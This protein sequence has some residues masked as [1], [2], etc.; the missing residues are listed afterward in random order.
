MAFAQ[1]LKARLETEGIQLIPGAKIE[2]NNVEDRVNELI[3]KGHIKDGG[4]DGTMKYYLQMRGNMI[5]ENL[6][7]A[8][9]VMPIITPILLCR[10]KPMGH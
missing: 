9:A 8:P 10:N 5:E 3:K 4:R 2:A 7:I 6:I 1:R